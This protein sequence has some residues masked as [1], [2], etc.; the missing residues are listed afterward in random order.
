VREGRLRGMNF[1]IQGSR[2]LNGGNP[3]RDGWLNEEYDL[4]RREKRFAYLIFLAQVLH[5][6]I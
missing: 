6:H 4:R 1:S 2:S 5:I 3:R